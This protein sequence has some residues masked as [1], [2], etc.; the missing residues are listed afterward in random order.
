M[1]H[2]SG[3]RT[4]ICRVASRSAVAAEG[5]FDLFPMMIRAGWKAPARAHYDCS[6]TIT[7]MFCFGPYSSAL[8]L[9]SAR[10]AEEHRKILWNAGGTSDAIFDHG[11]RYVRKHCQSGK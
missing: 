10:V 9:A 1:E 3:N 7:S 8:T 4:S 6:K 11:W 5:R 2:V